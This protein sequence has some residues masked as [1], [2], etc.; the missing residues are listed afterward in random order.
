M[1]QEAIKVLSL[2][3][4]IPVGLFVLFSTHLTISN[5]QID[6]TLRIGQ[7]RHQAS[8]SAS[9]TASASPVATATATPAAS[10]TARPT[11]PPKTTPSV[12]QP[13]GISMQDIKLPQGFFEDIGTWINAILPLILVVAVL[14]TFLYLIL[15][16]L[17]WITSGGD[18]SKVADARN[19]I[20][21]AVVGLL[22]LTASF[23]ILNVV[24]PLLGFES[25]NTV[26]ELLP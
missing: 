5:A 9:A 1:K 4:L 11:Q 21:S 18:K 8:P 19:T 6:T 22:V 20:I 2:L 26:L 7:T 17:R 3:L 14:L 10:P 12:W 15:G 24:L 13:M 23:A 16:G 25:L